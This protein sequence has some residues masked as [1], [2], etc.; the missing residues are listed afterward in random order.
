MDKSHKIIVGN[1]EITIGN[2]FMS[3]MNRHTKEVHL[4]Y[5]RD[6]TSVIMSTELEKLLESL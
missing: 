4:D 3:I 1:I 5:F 6:S 2:D